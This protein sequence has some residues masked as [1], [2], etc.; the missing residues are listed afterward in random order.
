ML[1]LK[2][3]K[4]LKKQFKKTSKLFKT[5]KRVKKSKRGKQSKRGGAFRYFIDQQINPDDRKTILEAISELCYNLEEVNK[6]SS[7][8]YVTLQ[9]IYSLMSQLNEQTAPSK[10]P[11]DFKYVIPFPR[12]DEIFKT[13]K[14]CSDWYLKVNPEF[15]P[16]DKETRREIPGIPEELF[17]IDLRIPVHGNDINAECDYEPLVMGMVRDLCLVCVL[18]EKIPKLDF[19]QSLNEYMKNNYK[20]ENKILSLMLSSENGI[21]NKSELLEKAMEC[22]FKFNE[23]IAES[24]FKGRGYIYTNF[25]DCMAEYLKF[26]S[27]GVNKLE[28]VDGVYK[29]GYDFLK[30]TV[31]GS[32]LIFPTFKQVNFTKVINLLGS[33]IGNFRLLN[34]QGMIHNNSEGPLMEIYHDIYAHGNMTHKSHKSIFR[35]KKEISELDIFD[36][37]IFRKS[38]H[39]FYTPLVK[40]IFI[41]KSKNLNK[42]FEYY[43]YSPKIINGTGEISIEEEDKYLL[44]IILFLVCHEQSVSEKTFNGYFIDDLCEDIQ[45]DNITKLNDE[46]FENAKRELVFN[47]KPNFIKVITPAE[48]KRRSLILL[49]K[50]YASIQESDRRG[51]QVF[52]ERLDILKK[53]EQAFRLS[54][55]S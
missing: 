32:Y 23:L 26:F 53:E 45:T 21:L 50:L 35:N 10:N 47:G 22:L 33:N 27:V 46:Q 41:Q 34:N 30:N 52:N 5:S 4:T 13:P 31:K 19:M 20:K 42:I 28:D 29:E 24:G 14:S 11:F 37:S 55:L 12:A 48:F 15:I 40:E 49:R 7:N 54:L 51:K 18:L 2:L 39:Y 43:N 38:V 3:K 16:F 17:D 9:H 8:K 44:A 1:N 25:I 36:L 6:R